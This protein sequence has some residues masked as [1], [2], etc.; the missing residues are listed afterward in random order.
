M[1]KVTVNM[2]DK[3]RSRHEPKPGDIFVYTEED[4][5]YEGAVYILIKY[6]SSG[7]YA[8]HN[9]TS[10]GLWHTPTKHIN[11]VFGNADENFIYVPH[12]ELTLKF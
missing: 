11:D 4:S 10:A 2:P 6:F 12:V 9:I 8:L 7:K 5:L 1:S 3:P